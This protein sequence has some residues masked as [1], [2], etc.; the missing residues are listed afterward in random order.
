MLHCTSLAYLINSDYIT[1]LFRL[2][3]VTDRTSRENT[4]L[5]VFATQKRYIIVNLSDGRRVHGWP[6]YYCSSPDVG[7]LYLYD[8]AWVTDNGYNEIDIHGLFLVKKDYIESI[9]FTNVTKDNAKE[10]NE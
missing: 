4:W 9:E 2:L 6:M 5:D 3:G 8:P 1:K 10:K 7:S